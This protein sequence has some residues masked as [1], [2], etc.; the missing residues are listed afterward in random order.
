MISSPLRSEWVPL[1]WQLTSPSAHSKGFLCSH[2]AKGKQDVE[3]TWASNTWVSSKE[4][5]SPR[6]RLA[7]VHVLR[8][9]TDSIA[10]ECGIKWNCLFFSFNS[11]SSKFKD[12]VWSANKL[13]Q[14]NGTIRGLFLNWAQVQTK[15]SLRHPAYWRYSSMIP[16]LPSHCLSEGWPWSGS[17]GSHRHPCDLQ[18]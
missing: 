2:W 10:E 9:A 7:T 1:K 13:K 3:N 6:K 11:K 14:A 17:S 12:V 4:F 8:K 18:N 5:G 16:L 15:G